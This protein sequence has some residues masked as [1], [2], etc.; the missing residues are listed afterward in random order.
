MPASLR[1]ELA[2]KSL[3][4]ATVV[5]PIAYARPGVSRDWVLG[6]SGALL[7]V[8][9]VVELARARSARMERAFGDAFG[10]ML[11]EHERR[12]A[13]APRFAGA[14][15]LLL[16]F[17]LAV[18]LFPRDLAVAAMCAVSLGDAA[19]A[20]VGR[21]IGRVRLRNGKSLEGAMACALATALGALFVARLGVVECLVGGACAALAELPARPLDDNVRVALATGTGILLWRMTLY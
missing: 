4:A 3:H 9:F 11:R 21:A 2:R 18:L 13:A 14:T 1:A 8:A 6:A 19:A 15:W 7:L 10:A 16:A 12:A 5:V 20:M 17:A